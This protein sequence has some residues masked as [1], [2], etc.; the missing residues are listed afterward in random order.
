MSV[1]LPLAALAGLYELSRQAPEFAERHQAWAAS[2]A[3]CRRVGK[4][5]L[6]IGIRRSPLE[7]PNGD[8]TLDI[9]PIILDVPGGVLGDER[10]QPFGDG[11]FGVC[12]NEHTMEHMHDPADVAAAVSECLR[13]A[14]VAVFLFPSPRS[15]VA[16]LHPTHH[17]R[18]YATDNGIRACDL[19]QG[20]ETCQV[21]PVPNARVGQ[22]RSL[23]IG[24][25]LPWQALKWGA[26]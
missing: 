4:P 13:V 6:R 15:I 1:W 16:R 10:L 3:Y 26:E 21:I 22:H 7:P 2:Q 8:Q 12:F 5:L 18:L 19:N 25:T 9:D 11:Q 14:D 24:S 17:L 23:V 20:D